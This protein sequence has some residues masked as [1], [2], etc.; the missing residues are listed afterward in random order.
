MSE[1]NRARLAFWGN[2]LSVPHRKLEQP[3]RDFT[4]ALPTDPDFIGKAM[5]AM[6]L[7][8]FNKIR[9]LAEVGVIVL[10]TAPPAFGQG[11][12]RRVGVYAFMQMPPYQAIRVDDFIRHTLKIRSSRHLRRAVERYLLLFENNADRLSGALMQ[13]SV[14]GGFYSMMNNYH[15][16]YGKKYPNLQVMVMDKNPIPGGKQELIRRLAT[17]DDPV[18]QAKLAA[19]KGLADGVLSSVLIPHPATVA[20]RIQAMTPKEALNAR[21][22]LE[23]GGY[24]ANPDLF[25]LWENKVKQA[26]DISTASVE[27]R[28]STRRGSDTA[29]EQVVK[30]AEDKAASKEAKIERDI[31]LIVDI[32][33]SMQKAIAF[34]GLLGER[35]LSRC[36][37]QIVAVGCNDSA[38]PIK[39]DKASLSMLAANGAT[40]LGIGLRYAVSKNFIPETVVILTDDRENRSPLY[41]EVKEFAGSEHI[42]MILEGG[43][44]SGGDIS[45]SQAAERAGWRTTRILVKEDWS[46][47]DQ[48][49]NILQGKPGRTIVDEILELEFPVA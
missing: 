3:V 49:S 12:L 17:I 13:P 18:E 44:V 22:W 5:Y 25:G 47:L 34:A 38:R 30:Q 9:D 11:L 46:A 32:S 19:D 10:L 4:A 42:F 39:L 1:L 23:E 29:V 43:I 21:G 35:V 6:T 24:L 45:A 26:K 2:A 15:L 27:H 31:L 20:V 33:G 41:T 7:T 8:K 36:T 48:V 16:D 28:K 40:S 14:R 37:G